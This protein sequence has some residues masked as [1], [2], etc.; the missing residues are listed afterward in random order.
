MKLH[1][2]RPRTRVVAAAVV[3]LAAY[4]VPAASDA[5]PGQTSPKEEQAAVHKRQGQVAVE[6]DLLKAHSDEVSAALKTIESNVTTQKAKVDEAKRAS[7]AAQADLKDAEDAVKAAVA[8][9]ENLNAASDE[10]AVSAYMHPPAENMLDAF[11][12][13]TISDATIKEAL[14]GMQSDA[15]ADVLD[16]LQ[17]AQE[18]VQV[19]RDNKKQVAADAE[20]KA[21]DASDAL[22]ALNAA[23]DQQAQFAAEAE[24]AL[25]QKLSESATLASR[26]K[27]L[28]DQ[29]AAEQAALARQLAAAAAANP[30]P[31]PSGGGGATIA[32]AP[33][34]LSTVS[35]PNGDGSITVAG[36]IAG[37]LRNMLNAAWNDGVGL[38][39]WGYRNPEEQIALRRAHCGTSQ[40]AIYEMPASQCSPPTA[41]PGTSRHEQGL[42]VDFTC[43]GGG[44]ISSH[45]SPCF[46]WM[47]AHA[48]DYGFYNLPSEPWHWSIDGR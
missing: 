45:G 16:Q 31:P 9:V 21:Q 29:I 32:S 38:C 43:N 6:I 35:C 37:N 1:L 14:I 15:D 8:K 4:L 24:D 26:D 25:D 40:Y 44:S 20:Q 17:K 46:V 39:G 47:D 10:F 30:A 42:A 28:S 36:Q 23:K 19:E 3:M 22:D 2:S 18:D 12:A 7:T 34:G 11:S 5:A 48:G 41:R 27:Q 13:D 33:G